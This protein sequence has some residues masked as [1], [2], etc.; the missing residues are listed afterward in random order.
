[1]TPTAV[2]E[3]KEL[4]TFLAG[5]SA[6]LSLT[7]V[8]AYARTVI[9]GGER[10]ATKGWLALGAGLL[11]TV[12]LLL[13]IVMASCSVFDSLRADGDIE[14][15]LVSLVA[16]WLTAVVLTLVVVSRFPVVVQY[17]HDSYRD[18]D[19]PW[20]AKVLSFIRSLPKL[21]TG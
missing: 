10:S 7:T 6:L 15:A 13:F 12:W 2:D 3:A 20:Y 14:P 9:E 1:M 21:L 11:T 8:L 4:L 16:T 18:D 5:P 19:R 17:I